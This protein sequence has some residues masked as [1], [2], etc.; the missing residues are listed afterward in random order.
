MPRRFPLRSAE[1]RRNGGFALIIVLWTLVLIGF[2][3][4]HLTASGRT[5]I[6]IAGN[7]VANS[8][9]QAAADG[10]IFEAIF[11][12][13]DPQPE[14]RWPADG[15]PR[16]VVVGR[17]RVILRVEDEASW[18][19]PS[20]APPALLEALL[21]VTGS[22]ADT[23]RRIA[24]AISGSVGS[25]ALPGQQE[26]L[27]AEYR[28]AGLDYGPPSAPFETL[29]ELGRVLGMTPAV[30]A[31]IRPHL[32]LFGPPEPNPATMDPVVAAALALS[33]PTA[34]PVVQPNQPLQDTLTVRITALA[35]GPGD[36]HV[37]RTAVVRTGAT[38][39]QGY[40]VLAWGSSLNSDAP[41]GPPQPSF[42]R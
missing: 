18:I 17:R 1:C 7:L 23:A 12:L 21:R 27:V 36:A 24:T 13:S 34:Q 35:S 41:L 8:A 2:I 11:N 37:T 32:T 15:T 3:V 19:N 4:A 28:A 6:R 39:P 38:L 16:Q 42:T 31:A 20:T 29:G 10:A 5:E 40:A 33:L 22:D 25:A 9:A 26:G 30:L 14:Q